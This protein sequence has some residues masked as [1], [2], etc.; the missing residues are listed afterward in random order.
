MKNNEKYISIKVVED[1]DDNASI[2]NTILLEYVPDNG[3]IY[4]ERSDGAK[5]DPE[6]MIGACL[7]KHHRNGD[8]NFKSY[9]YFY[10]KPIEA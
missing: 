3:I 8:I 7:A 10:L 5:L 9:N 4:S 6:N 2:N 1:I